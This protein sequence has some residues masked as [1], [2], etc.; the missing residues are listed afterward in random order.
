MFKNIFYFLIIFLIS[1]INVSVADEGKVWFCETENYIG[2]QNGNIIDN[3]N[4]KFKFKVHQNKLVF[5]GS[6]VDGVELP[7]NMNSERNRDSNYDCFNTNLSDKNNHDVF[8]FCFKRLQWSYI[9]PSQIV[10]N[11][12]ANCSTFD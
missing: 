3:G 5:K 4:F 11:I 12:L 6:K 8:S 2:I 9:I 10:M 7:L 1:F